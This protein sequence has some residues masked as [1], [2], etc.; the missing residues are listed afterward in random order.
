M[1]SMVIPVTLN[2]DSIHFILCS[3]S[4]PSECL[5]LYLVKGYSTYLMSETSSSFI[6]A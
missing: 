5:I 2:S 3:T 4:V 1:L 6:K